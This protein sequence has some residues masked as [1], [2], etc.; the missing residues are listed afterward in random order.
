[1]PSEKDV[2]FG[3]R[4]LDNAS[5]GDVCSVNTNVLDLSLTFDPNSEDQSPLKKVCF[6]EGYD[7]K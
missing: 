3:K 2:W 7:G 1:M 6:G 5:S 4:D